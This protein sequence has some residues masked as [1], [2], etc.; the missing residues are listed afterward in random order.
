MKKTFHNILALPL[1]MAVMLLSTIDARAIDLNNVNAATKGIIGKWSAD[2]V[3]LLK[4]LPDE[5]KDAKCFF[6]FQKGNPFNMTMLLRGSAEGMMLDIKI[7]FDGVWRYE[8]GG[9]MKIDDLNPQVELTDL[10][11]P[12]SMKEQLKASGLTEATIKQM[13]NDMFS[14]KAK[15]MIEDEDISAL[16]DFTILSLN[17]TEMVIDG[18]GDSVTLKKV[19]E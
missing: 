16:Q 18:D 3:I 10:T 4:E 1:L 11:I 19:V 14:A 12:E 17:D 6:T 7:T 2:P 8:A 15:Q 9:K 13:F 5:V